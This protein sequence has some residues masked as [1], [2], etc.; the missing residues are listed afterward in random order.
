MINREKSVFGRSEVKYLGVLVNRDGFRPDPDKI[1][2]V[3]PRTEEPETAQ[4]LPRY[5]FVVPEV[6]PGLCHDRRPSHTPY[7]EKLQ[8][9]VE[10]GITTRLRAYQGTRSLGSR[11]TSSRFQFSVCDSNRCK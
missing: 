2:P 9:R 8:V 6:S 11:L 7:E 10:R 3:I 1:A 4:A 5:G